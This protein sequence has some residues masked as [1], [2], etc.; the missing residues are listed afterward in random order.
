MPGALR[1]QRT[2]RHGG[3]ACP[4]LRRSWI[5]C[6]CAR[7]KPWLSARSRRRAVVIGGSVGGLFIANMLLRQ[8]WQVGRLRARRRGARLARAR[9]RQARRAGV[10]P[11]GRRRRGGGPARHRR[12]RPQRLRQVRQGDRALRLSAAPGRLERRLQPAAMPLS[13]SSSYHRGR[14]L[15]GIEHRKRQGRR[16][17]RGRCRRSRPTSSSAPMASAP[18][19]ARCARPRCCRA[20]P[21]TSPGAASWRSASFRQSSA[22]TPSTSSPSASRAQPVHR[23]SRARHRRVRRAVAAA[24]QLPVVLPRRPRATS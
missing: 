16:P 23:L 14:E 24:L 15:V 17:L 9:H 8:G 18:R 10:D 4:A 1:Q 22:R 13:P 5:R 3:A 12:H 21:A 19:C 2:A 20:M 11:G 6:R 7:G